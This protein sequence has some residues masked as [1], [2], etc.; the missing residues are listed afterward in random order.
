[1]AMACE[2]FLKGGRPIM[3]N[4]LLQEFIRYTENRFGQPVL[5][6]VVVRESRDAILRSAAW[7]FVEASE[8]NRMVAAVTGETG[9]PAGNLL[10]GFGRSLF[11][12]LIHL[13]LLQPDCDNLFD[14]LRLL[15]TGFY[16][17]LE[18][19]FPNLELP[20]LVCC[21]HDDQTLEL[22]YGSPRQWGS[23]AE[24]MIEACIEHFEERVVLRRLED[25]GD[26]E[27]V[28]FVLTRR[29]SRRGVGQ[30]SAEN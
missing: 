20:R 26:P 6:R 9:I 17:E 15:E 25:P 16:A 18:D 10:R 4:L 21:Q 14:Y 28:R 19:L 2:W 11:R 23:L 27:E 30:S 22:I 1:M 24:G 3:Q 5:E 7:R 8:L 12:T 13:P 29:E